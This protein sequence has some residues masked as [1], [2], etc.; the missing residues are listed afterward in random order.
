LANTPWARRMLGFAHIVIV[1]AMV[2]AMAFYVYE[3]SVS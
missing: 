3:V 1:P 2:A